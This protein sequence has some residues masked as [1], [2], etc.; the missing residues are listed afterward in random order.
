MDREK[1]LFLN[2]LKNIK[3]F[4]LES[5]D[6]A[7]WETRMSNKGGG[8]WIQ[9]RKKQEDSGPMVIEESPDEE[10]AAPITQST[11]PF[12]FA[13]SLQRPVGTLPLCFSQQSGRFVE[14]VPDSQ[15]QPFLAAS[16]D[17]VESSSA[18]HFTLASIP[19]G[20]HHLFIYLLKLFIH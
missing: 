11:T 9:R 1:F 14:T 18:S 15:E 16:Q 19:E 3:L 4:V 20:L 17:V 2:Q 6:C 13:S 10:D 7:K 8:G 12:A 5:I